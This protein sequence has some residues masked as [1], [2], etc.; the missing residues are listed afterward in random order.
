MLIVDPDRLNKLRDRQYHALVRW[1]QHGGLALTYGGANY[2]ALLQERA[3]Q[4]LPMQ[5]RGHRQFMALDALKAF[6][7]HKL[8]A[9]MPFLVLQADVGGGETVVAQGGIP[10]VVHKR[11]ANGRMFFLALDPRRPPF[12]RWA[13][14]ARFWDR[15]LSLAPDE[16]GP[17]PGPDA[18]QLVTTLST[19][20]RLKFP[21]FK[22]AVVFLVL[23][24]LMQGLLLRR[25]GRSSQQGLT[26]VRGLLAVIVFG[27]LLGYGFSYR[28]PAERRLVYNGFMQM[29][30][31]G[32]NGT[33]VGNYTLGL[34]SLGGA[35]YKLSFG[36]SAVPILPLAAPAEGTAAPSEY[37]LVQTP[38]GQ[39]I[40]GRLPSWSRSF[41]SL[42]P[43]FH[44]PL[45]G[46]A[47]RN[48]NTLE[49]SI[50][51]ASPHTILDGLICYDGRFFGLGDIAPR[52]RRSLRIA[53]QALADPDSI[54][55]HTIDRLVS[56]LARGGGSS[57]LARVQTEFAGHWLKAV[58]ADSGHGR[59]NVQ[60]IGWVRSGLIEPG[61]TS[62]PV[63]GAAAAVIRC[64]I[65][66][67]TDDDAV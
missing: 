17:A 2:G 43:R 41:F 55:P 38:A 15:I 59:Q 66:L 51:N 28:S 3:Q 27:S 56:G 31:D 25:C 40:R 7:G 14:R 62:G 54:D 24:G 52:H 16:L 19:V 23:Y 30:V 61:F 47:V 35:D 11:I 60:L 42:Q 49:I 4:L 37:V 57:L 58:Q 36:A 34:Y 33:A 13:Q 12:N 50:D 44:F 8:A 39:I 20:P 65:P 48:S 67:E 22:L 9:A 63:R 53:Q 18:S 45:T 32:R 46:M 10:I 26:H 21:N 1:L 5:V 6:C 29:D 64:R